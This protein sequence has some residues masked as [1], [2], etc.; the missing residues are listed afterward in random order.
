VEG[1]WTPPLRNVSTVL[2]QR[3]ALTELLLEKH[4]VPTAA[5]GK[6]A[7]NGGT[8]PHPEGQRINVD[9]IRLEEG[10]FIRRV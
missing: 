10:R 1:E 2:S 8:L 3:G 9:R 7:S 5:K 6:M 4:I